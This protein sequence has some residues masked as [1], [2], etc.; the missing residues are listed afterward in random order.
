VRASLAHRWREEIPVLRQR[1]ALHGPRARQIAVLR[2]SGSPL[3]SS[4]LHG[5]R[6]GPAPK[7]RLPPPG[8][9]CSGSWRPDTRLLAGIR[10]ERFF[11]RDCAIAFLSGCRGPNSRMPA[12]PIIS[13]RPTK[14]AILARGRRRSAFGPKTILPLL[15]RFARFGCGTSEPRLP[16]SLSSHRGG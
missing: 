13:S 10:V 8:R 12:V 16:W 2:D 4:Y 5:Y 15:Q 11:S 1:R 9:S 6:S 7:C 14:P 3:E